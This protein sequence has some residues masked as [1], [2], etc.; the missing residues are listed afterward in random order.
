MYQVLYRKY[1]PRVFSDV[2]GQDHVTSTLKNE[3][4]NGRISH[5]YLFTGS[6]MRSYSSAPVIF[7]SINLPRI[8][9]GV[10]PSK[11]RGS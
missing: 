5:A 1:R 2:Y 10:F 4:Q 9:S 7:T 6:A 8:S 11:N 3:I